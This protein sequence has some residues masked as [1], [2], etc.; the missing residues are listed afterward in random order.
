MLKINNKFKIGD[1]VKLGD[2]NSTFPIPIKKGDTGVIEDIRTCELEDFPYFVKFKNGSTW[3]A[4]YEIMSAPLRVYLAAPFFS[5]DQINK[6]KLLEN[7]LDKNETVESYFSPRKVQNPNGLELFTK[8]W[9]IDVMENDIKEVEKADIVVA[10][11]DFDGVDTDS[12]TAYEL[13]Y[14]IAKGKKTYLVNFEHKDM[15]NLML[16]GRNTAYFDNVKDVEKYDF[17]KSKEIP[18]EGPFR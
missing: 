18:F 1:K 13:G 2:F 10:I 12:G 17:T 9:A 15:V 11:V 5:D 8:D 16:T 6:V 7:A 14:A 3:F 4:D